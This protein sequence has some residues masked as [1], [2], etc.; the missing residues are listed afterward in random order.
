MQWA[1][2]NLHGMFEVYSVCGKLP[3]IAWAQKPMLLL[4]MLWSQPLHLA[5]LSKVSFLASQ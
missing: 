1:P 5:N 3:S 4:C 2:F